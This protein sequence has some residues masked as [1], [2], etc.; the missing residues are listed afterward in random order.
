M[1][2]DGIPRP[3]QL[4]PY[5]DPL[6]PY[7]GAHEAADEARRKHR[8]EKN[9]E[10][11]KKDRVHKELEQYHDREEDNDEGLTPE[12]HEQIMIFAKLRGIMN[13]SL[14]SGVLYRFHLNEDTGLVDLIDDRDESVVLTLTPE[15]LVQVSERM[16]RYAGVITDRKA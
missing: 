14:E 2:F 13:F 12:E 7:I 6:N 4:Q 11:Y 5:G 1:S 15:E 3:S 8:I 16:Q 9:R 10:S